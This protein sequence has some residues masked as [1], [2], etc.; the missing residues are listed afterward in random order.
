MKILIA[1]QYFYPDNFRINEIAYS[2]AAG[3]HDVT[4]LTGLP[5]Y[6]NGVA[7]QGYTWNRKRKEIINNVKVIRVSTIM[8]RSGVFWRSLNYLSFMINSTIRTRSL[9]KDFDVL[10]CYQSSP[11]TMAHA[12]VKMR[13]RLGKKCFLYCLDL[14]PESLKAWNVR[15]DS[16]L[17]HLVAKYSRW[18]YQNCDL[19][20]ISSLP[21]SDYLVNVNHVDRDRIVYLPQHSDEIVLNPIDSK[22]GSKCFVNFAFG[23]NIGKVQD[24]ECIIKAV[25][26]LCDLSNFVVHVFGNGSNLDMCKNLAFEL[27]AQKHIQFHGHI[28]KKELLEKYSEMDAFLLTLKG[29]GFIGMTM[30]AKLQEYMSA[31]KPVFAAINGAA[32]QVIADAKCGMV[33]PPSDDF[34]LAANMRKFIEMPEAFAQ[35]GANGYQYYKENFTMEVFMTR[36]QELLQSLQ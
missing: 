23:G 14:W 1:R 15:E 32:A 36:L 8:R 28:D 18:I 27:K 19:I 29:E 10:F 7:P 22:K 25:S 6:T 3:G 33:S 16:L 34:A 13:K 12:A 2:L 21:F 30:P 26:H 5:D 35:I 20:G 31:G 17:Y 11:I 24:V 4:V 9:G